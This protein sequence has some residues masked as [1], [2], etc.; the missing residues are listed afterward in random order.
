MNRYQGTAIRDQIQERL[1]CQQSRECELLQQSG[2]IDKDDDGEEYYYDDEDDDDAEY[3]YYEGNDSDDDY[4]VES[5][6]E[7]FHNHTNLKDE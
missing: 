4:F 6:D 7:E 5:C 1:G 2:K 3:Y